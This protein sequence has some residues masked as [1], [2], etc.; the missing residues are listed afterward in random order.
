MLMSDIGRYF[1]N[2]PRLFFLN[3]GVTLDYF[4]SDGKEDNDSDMLNNLHSGYFNIGAASCKSRGLIESGPVA[5]LLSTIF[6]ISSTSVSV[7]RIC[8]SPSV[9]NSVRS[10]GVWLL[11][12]SVDCSEK[13]LLNK[14]DLSMSSNTRLPLCSIGGIVRLQSL[15]PVKLLTK[16]HPFFTDSLF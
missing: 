2:I 14:S 3:T 12:S 8:R 15:F 6:S 10:G 4:H 9:C 1:F 5:L 16:V 11:S 7:M 13:N